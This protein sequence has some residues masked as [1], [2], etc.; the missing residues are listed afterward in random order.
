[1]MVALAPGISGPATAKNA[2]DCRLDPPA[3]PGPNDGLFSKS[4]AEIGKIVD[5]KESRDEAGEVRVAREVAAEIAKLHPRE[6]TGL[7]YV[8][9]DLR[10]IGGISCDA[11]TEFARSLADN[12]D[13]VARQILEMD[14]HP[15]R[16]YLKA[17]DRVDITE[18]GGGRDERFIALDRRITAEGLCNERVFFLSLELAEHIGTSHMPE[19]AC[20]RLEALIERAERLSGVGVNEIPMKWYDYHW[21]T[22]TAVTLCLFDLALPMLER[23]QQEARVVLESTTAS[24]EA[25]EF[26]EVA[27]ENFVEFVAQEHHRASICR[28][29]GA[30]FDAC[31]PIRSCRNR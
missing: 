26:V 16:A 12:I 9:E 3:Y 24:A 31:T 14:I 18:G 15:M 19:A 23:A 29:S 1:M 28:L 17:K 22:A 6:A 8:V 20:P 7:L 11:E 2:T 25:K 4:L 5:A 10:G 21:L 13:P 30:A 27:M